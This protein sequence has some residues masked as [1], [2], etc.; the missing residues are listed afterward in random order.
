MS[1]AMLE[2]TLHEP[3][4]ASAPLQ[5]MGKH[6]CRRWNTAVPRGPAESSFRCDP[7]TL[8]PIAVPCIA[9][10]LARDRY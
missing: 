10:R 5:C 2:T 7:A 9:T 6:A 3:I 1:P 4:A 8:L